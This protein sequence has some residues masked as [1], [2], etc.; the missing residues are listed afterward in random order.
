[1]TVA[2]TS[3]R[4]AVPGLLRHA[5][6]ACLLLAGLAAQAQPGA[7]PAG[8]QRFALVIG[9]AA[10]RDAPLINPVNDARGIAEALQRSGFTVVR[11]ENASQRQM[12]EAITAFGDRIRGGGVGL[13]YFSGHGTQVKGRNFLLPVDQRIE[14]EDEVPYRAIDVGQV[15]DKMESAKNSMN[16]LILDACRNNP[17]A[18]PGRNL[19][20]GLA[21]MEA[22]VGTFIA[23]ATA[24]GAVALDGVG[25]GNGVY[26]RHLLSHMRQPGLKIEDVFKR[27]RSAVRQESGEA[28][29]RGKTRRWRV[30]SSSLRRSLA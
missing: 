15:L 21:P 22:P 20:V 27:V 8:Q 4:S 24:P 28:R 10:Y 30:T 19:E 12:A 7:P 16:L 6:L 3:N 9:N 13:F 1:M 2:A 14:R 18:R 5:L 25:K 29:Y 17:F 11:L 23:F 26:T